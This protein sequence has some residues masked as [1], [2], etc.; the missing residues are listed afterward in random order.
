MNIFTRQLDEA[1]AELEGLKSERS[2]QGEELEAL[3]VSGSCLFLVY[4]E[5]NI[6]LPIIVYVLKEVIPSV[7]KASGLF[8]FRSEH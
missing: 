2:A 6:S 7:N 8:S 5:N 3:R 4:T 1:H